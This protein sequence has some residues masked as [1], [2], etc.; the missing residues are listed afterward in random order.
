MDRVDVK[1]LIEVAM[2]VG[3]ACAPPF[4]STAIAADKPG[5]ADPSWAPERLPGFAIQSC[6]EKAWVPVPADLVG[7]GRKMLEGRRSTVEYSLTDKSKDPTNETA[8]RHYAEQ[9]KKAGAK[10]MSDPNGGW[11]A[12]LTQTTPQGEFWYIYRHGSGNDKSTATYTITTVQVAPLALEVQVQAPPATLETGGTVCKDPPWLVKQFSY[13]RIE[14]CNNRDFD[15]VKL[16]LP[17]G[18]KIIA[19]HVIQTDYTLTD[20]SKDPS[21]LAVW[22]NYA[23]TLQQLGAKLVSD[24]K[25]AYKAVL[26][27]NTPQG[28]Y[29]YV[30]THTGGNEFSTPTYSLMTVQVGGPPPKACTI[31]VYGV[32]FDFNKSILRPDSEPVLNQLLAMFKSDPSYAAEIGG[33]TDNIG[34]PDYNRALSGER[35]AAVKDWLASHGIAAARLNTAGYGDTRPLVPNTNDES[36]ARN[37]RVELKRNECK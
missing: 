34:K 3:A 15:S 31:Q 7:N 26:T 24:P 19:G 16:N 25:A 17:G 27:S 5:C 22:K 23:E 1:R 9:G 36:R 11:S 4:L 33:H 28:E 32:N 37:R 10:L 20:R 30:Y 21:A 35:A 13:F 14:R 12:T 18:E 2:T 29:W 6:E 8:R